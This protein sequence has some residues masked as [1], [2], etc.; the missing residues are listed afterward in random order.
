M[1]FGRL[2]LVQIVA[3]SRSG[4]L[5]LYLLK[6]PGLHF[7]F[8]SFLLFISSFSVCLSLSVFAQMCLS[9]SCEQI[10]HSVPL[11]CS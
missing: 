3:V 11:G 10:Q 5:E 4:Q 6:S 2:S 7:F 9:G 1:C 8:L